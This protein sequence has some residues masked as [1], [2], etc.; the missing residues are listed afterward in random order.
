MSSINLK[1]V[2]Q[3]IKAFFSETVDDK[4]HDTSGAAMMLAVTPMA[5]NGAPL[6][7]AIVAMEAAKQSIVVSGHHIE[8]LPEAVDHVRTVVDLADEMFL[9]LEA[10]KQ[11]NK[12]LQEEIQRLKMDNEK[13]YAT[14]STARAILVDTLTGQGIIEARIEKYVDWYERVRDAKASPKQDL[15]TYRMCKSVVDLGNRMLELQAEHAASQG[16]QTT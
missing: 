4:Y 9:E 7:P 8:G 16:V 6:L 13:L 15:Y 14:L 10:K 2:W 12:K 1:N 5:Y 11:H 3:S